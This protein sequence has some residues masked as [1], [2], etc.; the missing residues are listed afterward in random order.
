MRRCYNAEE[1]VK[2]FTEETI[3]LV[4]NGIVG[5]ED[6]IREVALFTTE[7]TKFHNEHDIKH[8]MV[9]TED[10]EK[11]DEEFGM[12]FLH[13]DKDGHWEMIYMCGNYNQIRFG[14]M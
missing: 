4:G 11:M 3:R 9:F 5:A 10:H 13:D 1:V 7:Y 12:A 6:G 14:L 2:V 8:V